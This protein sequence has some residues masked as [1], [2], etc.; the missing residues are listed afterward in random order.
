MGFFTGRTGKVYIN[1]DETGGGTNQLVSKVRSW[2]LDTTV[3][4]YETTALGDS[5]RSFVPG[6]FGGTGTIEMSYYHVDGA[7]DATNFI[8]LTARETGATFTDRIGLVLE[9][10]FNQTF[11]FFAYITS[12]SIT[13]TTDE[14]STVSASFTI[15][16][17]MQDV[18]LTGVGA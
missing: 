4:T 10:G 5:A 13:S 8:A 3:D 6:L 2:S 1:F 16:G 11:A 17:L 15:D 14:L 7:Y 12:V 18:T 9:T